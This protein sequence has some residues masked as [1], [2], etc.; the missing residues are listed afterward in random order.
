[1][2]LKVHIIL[3]FKYKRKKVKLILKKIKNP[4]VEW[5]WSESSER[6]KWK[7]RRRLKKFNKTKKTKKY[8]MKITSQTARIKTFISKKKKFN[9]WPSKNLKNQKLYNMLEIKVEK[10][11]FWLWLMQQLNLHKVKL[12]TDFDSTGPSATTKGLKRL[13]WPCSLSSL[14]E[15]SK[16]PAHRSTMCFER[17]VCLFSPS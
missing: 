5:N 15:Y 12:K 16:I 6:I 8:K 14:S 11:K 4:K 9:N 1:M 10:I 13:A 3:K 2:H 17:H 7:T